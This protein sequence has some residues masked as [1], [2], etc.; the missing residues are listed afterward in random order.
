MASCLAL[1]LLS[2][3]ALTSCGD[4]DPDPTPEV[5][6]TPDTPEVPDTPDE[7]TTVTVILSTINYYYS[8]DR[9]A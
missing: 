5:P 8:N 3:M 1:G 6:D 2:G 9:V 7:P 4:D